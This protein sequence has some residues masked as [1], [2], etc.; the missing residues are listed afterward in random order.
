[1]LIIVKDNIISNY[2]DNSPESFF[3]LRITLKD[4]IIKGV[5]QNIPSLRLY[6]FLKNLIRRILIL[7]LY[8]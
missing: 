6:N 4:I 2:S 5:F 3:V 7:H 1:M 8:Q